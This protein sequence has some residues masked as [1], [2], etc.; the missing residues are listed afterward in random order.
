MATRPVALVTGTSRGIGNHLARH[1]LASGYDVVGCSRSEHAGIENPAY[2]HHAVDVG[3][4]NEVVGLFRAI[5]RE[6]GGL[7][8]AINNAAVNSL[9]L[10]ALTSGGAAEEVLRTNLLG[11]F[12]VCRES[13]KAMIGRGS[14]RIVNFGSV[15]V[16]HEC[17][18]ES[19]YTASKA[20]VDAMTRVLA[21]EAAHHGITCN[22]VAPAAVETTSMAEVDPQRLDE[23]LARN[24]IPRVGSMSEVADAV[25]FLIGPAGGAVTGQLLYLGGA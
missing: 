19:V 23:L 2:S 1:L 16:R 24:A 8:V 14:G 12:L 21:K 18:G 9:S 13:I 15:A 10:A 22:V 3:A 20:G 25:D 4:E 5:R 7:D 17:E 11:T 6:H